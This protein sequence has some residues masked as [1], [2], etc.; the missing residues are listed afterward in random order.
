MRPPAAALCLL[1]TGV[2]AETVWIEAEALDN[3]GG[4]FT[5]TQPTLSVGS[6]YLMAHGLG[7]PVADATGTVG[8]AKAGRYRAWVRTRDW[9]A[10]WGAAGQPGRFELHVNGKPTGTVLGT[11]GTDWFWQPA[12]EVEL[13]AGPARLALRDLT[14][15]NGRCDALVLSSDPSY[16]PPED[17]AKL[18]EE[19]WRRNN[20][21]GKPEDLGA[22]DLVVVGGGYAGLATAVSAARQSLRVALIQDRE[23]LGG[24]GSSEIA[25]WAMG[26]TLRGKYPRLGEIVE[27]FSDR[28][29]DSPAPAAAF[30]DAR[31]EAVARAEPNLTLLLGHYAMGVTMDGPRLRSV[32][33]LQVRTGRER[34]VRGK[35]FADCTGHGHLGVAAG[36]DHV[37]TP[38]GRMG[39]S[40]LWYHRLADGP[41]GWPA[42]PWA[43][44]L[45]RGDF[46]GLPRSKGLDGD[47]PFFKGEWFWESGYDL[48]P[49]RDLER[50][51]DWN[52]R[53]VFG[54]FS[55]LKAPVPDGPAPADKAAAARLAAMRETAERAELRWVSPVGG[56]RETL[57]L[58]GDVVLGLPDFLAK[59]EYPD[60]CIPT[61]WDIDLHVPREQFAKKTPDNPFIS[62][63]IFGAHIDRRNGYPVPYR[64]LYSRNVPNLFMAGRN[65]SVT[66]EAL[67]T[68]R[69]MRTCGM[70]GEVVG[71]AAYLA[72]LHGTDP[73]GV[74]DRHLDELLGLLREP[75]RMRRAALR[76]PLVI[77][78]S[79]PDPTQAPRHSTN[80]DL[81]RPP[82]KPKAP[83]P[84]PA[85]KP[86]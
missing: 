85:S 51:R 64:C 72:L 12:G 69:V 40:N 63:A 24:N 76:E 52:L 8:I 22:F 58:L 41:V 60:G 80:R 15:F 54:A 27:E 31:K 56:T 71:K 5:D 43:L 84:A 29:Q 23:V 36:A 45:A 59:R 75:G 4:W 2:L 21:R 32:K 83:T 79:I 30:D 68:V 38:D 13:P 16:T 35:L 81:D 7:K 11:K 74:H 3:R 62:R 73:R 78:A 65:I 82:P 55:A 17:P 6:P 37:L 39:M 18:A 57:Q 28:A 86:N 9:V 1:A 77:D 34:E 67:G 49:V 44:D 61:T 10:P 70:M 48:H 46:P 26:G 53:A 20:P 42:T 66:R 19:R 33:L 14:G 25:V 47:R 50:I